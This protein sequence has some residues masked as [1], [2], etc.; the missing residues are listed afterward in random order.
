[1]PNYNLYVLN[2]YCKVFDKELF[3]VMSYECTVFAFSPKSFST[4]LRNLTS[5]AGVVDEYI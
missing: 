2:L 5:T 1:M 3:E 4:L